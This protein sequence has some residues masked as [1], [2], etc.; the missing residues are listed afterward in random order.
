MDFEVKPIHLGVLM[1]CKRKKIIPECIQDLCDQE[2]IK[3]TKINLDNNMEDQGPFD[4]ILH[5]VSDLYKKNSSF[6]KV[7]QMIGVLSNYAQRFPNTYV[8]DD[9]KLVQRL[10]NRKYQLEILKECALNVNGISVYAPK[11][12][13]LCD[14]DNNLS[15]IEHMQK[16]ILSCDMKFP[17]LVKPLPACKAVDAHKFIIIFSMEQ[18]RDITYPCLLQEFCN[19]SG[20]LYKMFV[21]GD[22][23]SVFERPSVKNIECV[24][25]K[26]NSLTFDTRQISK[27]GNNFNPELHERD[28]RTRTWHSYEEDPLLLDNVV[29]RA[30]HNKISNYA[31]LKLYGVD[32][33][34][35][36]QGDY[37]VVDLNHFPGYTGVR[38]QQFSKDIV[39]MIKQCA[40][41]GKH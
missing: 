10:M 7:E 13:E 29:L 38:E 28:P 2:S 23:I 24:N 35:D 8:I 5:K 6:E 36:L 31:D 27:I 40:K 12:L 22:Q 18:L 33:L 19:H 20:V 41:K 25:N 9:F 39:R 37:A 17:I 32:I 3:I 4:V 21:I 14:L 16:Q 34:K 15:T 1:P 30:I 11:S 26:Q